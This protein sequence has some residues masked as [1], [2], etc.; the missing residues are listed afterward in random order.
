MVRP[1]QL[2]HMCQAFRFLEKPRRF[3][4]QWCT[5]SHGSSLRFFV[6]SKWDGVLVFSGADTAM[7]QRLGSLQAELAGL[8]P[9]DWC[10]MTGVTGLASQS[11]QQVYATTHTAPGRVGS[12]IQHHRTRRSRIAALEGAIL[13]NVWHGMV[14]HGI[15]LRTEAGSVWFAGSILSDPYLRGEA[16]INIKY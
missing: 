13:K 15:V 2:R 5:H 12:S 14:W 8:V 7:C 10:H 3:G 6:E 1:Q 4:V 11:R 16:A 9:Q